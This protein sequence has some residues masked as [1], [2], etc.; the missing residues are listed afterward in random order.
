MPDVVAEAFPRLPEVMARADALGGQIDRT[1]IDLAEAVML[2]GREGQTF[3]SVVTDVDHR[4]AR[5]QL[6]DLPVVA[7]VSARRVEPGDEL[8]VKLTEANPDQRI[9]TFQR[10]G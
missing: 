4:G 5:I 10:A 8:R 6:R 7:R 1:V 9:V 2:R 3:P